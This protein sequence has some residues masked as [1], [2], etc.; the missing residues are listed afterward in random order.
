MSAINPRFEVVNDATRCTNENIGAVLYF[1]TLFFVVCTP[2]GK[3]CFKIQIGTELFCIFMNLYRKFAGWCQNDGT[4]FGGLK[5]FLRRA[6]E[7]V[8]E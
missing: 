8:P 6:R 1:T 2:V 3:Y 5:V 4:Q 7:L